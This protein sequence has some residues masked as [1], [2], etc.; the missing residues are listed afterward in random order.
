MGLFVRCISHRGAWLSSPTSRSFHTWAF[1]V[2]RN[3]ANIWVLPCSIQHALLYPGRYV[4]GSESNTCPKKED[5]YVYND[6][7]HKLF[8]I[9]SQN[10]T[11]SLSRWLWSYFPIDAKNIGS[12]SNT[13]QKGRTLPLKTKSTPKI[14]CF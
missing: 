14:I 6:N 5:H 2:D 9:S 7:A 13:C 8:F 1:Q 11:F 10:S 12:K 3:R 4:F